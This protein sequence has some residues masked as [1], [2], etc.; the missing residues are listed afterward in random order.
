MSNG[1]VV[2]LDEIPEKVLKTKRFHNM[3]LEI[4]NGTL[5]RGE[6]YVNGQSV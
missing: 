2:G 1:K 6:N 4:Y 5:L 3:L